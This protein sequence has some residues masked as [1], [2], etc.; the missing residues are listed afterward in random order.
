MYTIGDVIPLAV[1]E[2]DLVAA[3]ESPVRADHDLCRMCLVAQA[4][5]RQLGVLWVEVSSL[6]VD[7]STK[8]QEVHCRCNE[9]ATKLVRAYDNGSV[10]ANP[11]K[12]LPATISLVV[13]GV[14]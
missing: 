14:E 10:T 2:A 11:E 6:A 8:N 1:I 3:D 5:Y 13:H 9:A 7:F 12:Y 4:A